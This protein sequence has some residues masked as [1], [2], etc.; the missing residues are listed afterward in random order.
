MMKHT[1]K[2]GQECKLE[3]GKEK[4]LTDSSIQD[5][6]FDYN[7]SSILVSS[8]FQCKEVTNIYKR[9]KKAYWSTGKTNFEQMH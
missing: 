6:L 2:L 3:F 5:I 1:W 4:L 8:Q 9:L 7:D